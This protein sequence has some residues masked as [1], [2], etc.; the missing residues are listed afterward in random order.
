MKILQNTYLFLRLLLIKAFGMYIDWWIMQTSEPELWKFVITWV[1]L[2]QVLFSFHWWNLRFSNHKQW[3]HTRDTEVL[4]IY[5]KL[6][7][8]KSTLFTSWACVISDIRKVLKQC[9]MFTFI[10]FTMST[11]IIYLVGHTPTS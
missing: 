4:N 10:T 7:T 1:Y 5:N 6:S 3:A 8:N 2:L 11:C 9:Q